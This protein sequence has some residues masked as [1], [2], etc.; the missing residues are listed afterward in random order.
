[1]TVLMRTYLV[2]SQYKLY[3][4]LHPECIHLQ[5]LIQ[6]K[7]D[8]SLQPT[9]KVFFIFLLGVALVSAFTI[10]DPNTNKNVQETFDVAIPN[11]GQSML[12]I[13]FGQPTKFHTLK[14]C[15]VRVMFVK[16]CT[17]VIP[18]QADMFGLDN[19]NEEMSDEEEI[20]PF[21]M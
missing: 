16:F 6:F 2:Y 12:E 13:T 4:N 5:L 19:Q 9:M 14:T 21:L 1:M 15:W 11:Q 10:R 17:F 3:C 18:D 20:K 8:F 7:Q